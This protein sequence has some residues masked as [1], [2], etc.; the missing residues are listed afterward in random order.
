[1]SQE[2]VEIVRSMFK[3]VGGKLHGNFGYLAPEVEFHTSGV[4]PDLDPVYRGRDGFQVLNDRLNAPWAEISLEPHRIIDIGERVLV[5]SHFEARGRDGIEA[6]RPIALLWTLQNAQVVRID[7]F[8]DQQK[9]F[10]AVGL[11]EQDA[12]AAS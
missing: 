10:Q 1:M 2:N 11:S 7:A 6:R 3:T 9:A 8:S 12:R 5:L 4:F